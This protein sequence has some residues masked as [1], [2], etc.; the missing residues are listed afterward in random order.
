M[1][2]V[3]GLPLT[4]RSMPLAS[5]ATA[6][7]AIG[8]SLAALELLFSWP[9]NRSATGARRSTSLAS[10][11]SVTSSASEGWR[12]FEQRTDMLCQALAAAGRDVAGRLL[13][14]MRHPRL[15]DRSIESAA[16]AQHQ[17]YPQRFE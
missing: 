2:C 11:T 3:S 1:A 10:C 15:H 7:G 4:V 16:I 14:V 8:L 9:Y 12:A 17:V 5:D 13:Q 6:R